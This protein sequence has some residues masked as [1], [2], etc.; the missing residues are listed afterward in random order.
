MIA[1]QELSGYVIEMELDNEIYAIK[2]M[3]ELRKWDE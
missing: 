1:K 3:K 2:S